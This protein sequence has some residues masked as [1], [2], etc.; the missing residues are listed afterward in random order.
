MTFALVG[1]GAD[2]A[3]PPPLVVRDETSGDEAELAA[4]GA[5]AVFALADASAFGLYEATAAAAA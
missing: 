5:T 4:V 2:G 1:G 3:P